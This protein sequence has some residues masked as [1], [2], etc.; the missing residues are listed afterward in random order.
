VLVCARWSPGLTA[1][2]KLVRDSLL[3]ND[4]IMRRAALTLLVR[5]CMNVA[6]GGKSLF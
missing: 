3:R 1:P 6:T 4:S 2:G 5:T